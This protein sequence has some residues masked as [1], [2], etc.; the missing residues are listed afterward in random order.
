MDKSK[1]KTL[2]V[3]GHVFLAI[4][5]VGLITI[6]WVTYLSAIGLYTRSFEALHKMLLMR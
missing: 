5:L 1:R 6:C 2:D 4:Q 3:L